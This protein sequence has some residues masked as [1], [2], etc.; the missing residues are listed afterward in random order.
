MSSAVLSD[1]V[2]NDDAGCARTRACGD[3]AVN[4]AAITPL[5]ICN[6]SNLGTRDVRR[7]EQ[8]P[9]TDGFGK[10]FGS[11]RDKFAALCWHEH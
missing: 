3:A 4:S 8:V 11:T 10:R 9:V 5:R 6:S 2:V 1:C 7:G